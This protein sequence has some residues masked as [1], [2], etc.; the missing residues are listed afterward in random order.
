MSTSPDRGI[1]F[2]ALQSVDGLPR[3][4]KQAL[5]ALWDLASGMACMWAAF[6]LRLGTID[7]SD[8]VPWVDLLVPALLVPPIFWGMGL[9]REI[10]RYIGV[11]YVW[12]LV[13]ACVLVALVLEVALFTAPDRYADVPWRSPIMAALLLWGAAGGARLAVRSA[14]RQR[15]PVQHRVAILGASDV[16]AGLGAALAHDRLSELVA[17]FDD[18]PT[19]RGGSL[20]GVRIHPTDD[21]DRVLE[22]ER[23]DSLLVALGPAS[24]SKRR[25]LLEHAAARGVRV[26]SVP[27]LA[28]IK[29]GRVSVSSLRPLSIED[30]LGRPP[31]APIDELLGADVSGRTVLVTG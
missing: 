25:A 27:T 13:K 29:D 20:R 18:A 22:H 10:T 15:I 9:Y 11:Q 2:E 3:R 6:S 28:E 7:T 17:Y 21:F 23:F 14:L 8:H 26:L 1:A 16:G 31:V 4:G 24:R 30:L 12:R 19:L 5:M